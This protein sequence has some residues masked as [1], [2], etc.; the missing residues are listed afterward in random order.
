M[1]S[2]SLLFFWPPS[3]YLFSACFCYPSF[4]I[5]LTYLPILSD[6]FISQALTV[7]LDNLAW[8]SVPL[9]SVIRCHPDILLFR[10]STANVNVLR[11]FSWSIICFH[12]I[13]PSSGWGQSWQLGSLGL[14]QEDNGEFQLGHTS[15]CWV[16]MPS[17]NCWVFIQSESE[18]S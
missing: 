18:M 17:Q 8:I 14:N 2:L 16:P 15:L 3:L 9:T 10:V 5:C 13:L 11:I 7:C 12:G 4:W 6:Q 1:F